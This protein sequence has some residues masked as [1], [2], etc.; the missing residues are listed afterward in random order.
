MSNSGKRY[1]M[2]MD[3]RQC[4]GCNAC[5]LAC[6]AENNLPEHGFRDWIVTETRG[7]F[8]HLSQEIRSERCNH[9]TTAPCVS[10]CPTGA[11][12]VNEGGTVLVSRDKCTGCKACIAACPYDARYVHPEGFVDKCTFCLHRVKEGK[13]PAC[14]EVCPTTALAFG[15][16]NDPESP[17]SRLLRQRKHRVLKPETGLK[18]N[19]FILED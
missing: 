7:S 5:V 14:V 8:P 9:C 16:L 1:A 18:P 12:H 3:P 13:D 17:V 6:K 2:T 19:L 4:V 11:S 10:A 15:D